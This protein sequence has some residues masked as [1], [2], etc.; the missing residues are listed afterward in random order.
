MPIPARTSD[1]KKAVVTRPHRRLDGRQA[2]SSLR[3][4]PRTLAITC[5]RRASASYEEVERS[6]TGFRSVVRSGRELRALESTLAL[7]RIRESSR[8]CWSGWTGLVDGCVTRFK[9]LVAEGSKMPGVFLS[10]NSRNWLGTGVFY[11]ALN[12][13]AKNQSRRMRRII[14]RGEGC[15]RAGV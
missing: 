5:V 14:S 8:A 9:G 15:A 10:A 6:G 2:R 4:H 13:V 7:A 12:A 11:A 3:E 1:R